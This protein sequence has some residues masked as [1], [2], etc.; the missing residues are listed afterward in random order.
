M[1]TAAPARAPGVTPEALT[2]LLA[3]AWRTSPA[4]TA[5][6]WSNGDWRRQ[7]HLNLISNAVASMAEKPL[8]LI[9]SMPPRHGKSVLLS[10]WTPVWFLANWPRGRVGLASYAADFA[11]DWGLKARRTIEQNTGLGIQLSKERARAHDWQT[12]QGGGMVTAGVGGP[13]T[14]RGF[15][16]LI[17]DDPIK[18]R[19]EANSATHRKHIWDWWTSTARTRLEPGG[20]IIIVATRWHEDDLIGRLLR[21]PDGDDDYPDLDEWQ[22]IRLPALAE[23]DDPLDRELDEPL[24]PS[25]YD[26][27]A[28]GALRVEL[29]SQDWAGLFQQR[30]TEYGG[31]LF[32]IDWWRYA[33]PLPPATGEVIQ[34]WDTAFKTG[35][36]NDYSACATMYPAAASYVLREM[37]RDRLEFPDLVRS[38]ISQAERHQPARIYIEDAA[39]GQSLIQSLQTSTRLPIV[40]VKVDADKVSRANAITGQNEAGNVLLPSRAPWI[41]DFLDETT[42]FPNGANDDQVDAYVGALTQ[43]AVKPVWD[44][45]IP[46]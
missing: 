25:R 22:N 17:V 34:F 35:Q 27:R 43:L 12:E 19:Q 24:W 15:D 11:S 31:G 39:S 13:L 14:G 16:L 1:A 44:A 40:P 37:W 45:T 42:A 20:S 23:E 6:K 46:D 9:V 3:Q 2:A 5:A 38:V 26:A 33:D 21:G 28:L 7:P 18:N 10:H 30:P 32:K 29:G 41:P 8:R 4:A 36:D